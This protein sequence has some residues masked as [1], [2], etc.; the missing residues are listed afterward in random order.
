M[1]KYAAGLQKEG[2]NRLK[3]FHCSGTANMPSA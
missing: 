2:R 3:K 1:I